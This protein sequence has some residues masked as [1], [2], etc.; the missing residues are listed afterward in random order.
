MLVT[1]CARALNSVLWPALG[2][3]SVRLQSTIVQATTNDATEHSAALMNYEYNMDILK[4]PDAFAVSSI[5]SLEQMF[6]HRMHLGHKSSSVNP[7]MRPY[8]FGSRFDQLIIDLDK[9]KQQMIKALN[10][11]AHIAYRDGIILFITRHHQTAFK[12]EK[13]AKECSEYAHTR[14]WVTGL[15]TN[16]ANLFGSETR[17]PDCA[18]FFSTRGSEAAITECAKMLIPTVGIVDTD[19]D[20]RLICYPVAGNDDSPSSVSL[21][22]KYFKTAILRGKEL[23]NKQKTTLF[24]AEK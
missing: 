22:C 1:R 24:N 18:I 2:S 4:E 21:Y 17:L 5:V 7:H 16:A 19:S 14:H 6:L 8:I 12:V 10:F 20:P 11:V 13:C 9:S 23:R 3:T 15:F